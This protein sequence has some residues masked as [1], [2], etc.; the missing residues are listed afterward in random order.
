MEE[1]PYL[2][3]EKIEAMLNR[4]RKV[5][6]DIKCPSGNKVIKLCN[7]PK[8]KSALRCGSKECKN[9]GKTVHLACGYIML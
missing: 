7:N 5:T 6:P 8:C 1:K 2:P 3:D 9:C 4:L